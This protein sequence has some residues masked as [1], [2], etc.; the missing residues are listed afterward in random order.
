MDKI[1]N[2]VRISIPITTL[3]R[4]LIFSLI[5][6]AVFVVKELLFL[7]LVSVVIATFIDAVA[8]RLSR[9]HIPRL[10]SIIL[11]YIIMI[12]GLVALVYALVPTLFYELTHIVGQLSKYVPQDKLKAIIDPNAIKSIGSFINN[13]TTEV[14]ASQ[15]AYSTKLLFTNVSGAS[16]DVIQAL[17]GNLANLILII[18]LSFYL[19]IQERGVEGFLKVIIPLKYESYVIDLWERTSYKIALW[20]RGQVFLAILMALL[21]FIVLSIL[22]VPYALLL[23]ILTLVCELIPFGIIFATIPAVI[24][25]FAFG[26]MQM[27]LIVLLVYFLLHELEVYVFLPIVNQRVNGIS[28]LMVILALLIGFELAGFWGLVLSMPVAILLLELMN[29]AKSKKESLRALQSDE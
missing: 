20:F 14:P 13:I 12:F 7:L 25:G 22:G 11:M 24:T 27:G 15:V 17:F 6:W 9:Y 21:T 26:G 23:S 29:D 2:K 1:S 4:V 28:P 16:Y 18:I 10:L 5:V 8:R 19:S 3:F